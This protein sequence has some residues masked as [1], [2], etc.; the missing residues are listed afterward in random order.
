MAEL[1][2]NFNIRKSQNVIISMVRAGFRRVTEA[3]FS[4]EVCIDFLEWK[5]LN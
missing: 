3:E 1:F 5:N 4:T 2:K